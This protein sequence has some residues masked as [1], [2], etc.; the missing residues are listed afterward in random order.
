MAGALEAQ[1]ERSKKNEGI[2]S[3]NGLKTQNSVCSFTL[4]LCNSCGE[5]QGRKTE[6]IAEWIM[7]DLISWLKNMKNWRR[8]L[9][10]PFR[11]GNDCDKG[12]GLGDELYRPDLQAPRRLCAVRLRRVALIISCTRPMAATSCGDEGGLRPARMR[13]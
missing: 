7:N 11:R 5:Y 13:L 10:R 3:S 8:S 9:T 6:N 1:M 4:P 12:K 2:R